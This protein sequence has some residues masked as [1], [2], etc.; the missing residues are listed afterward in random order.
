MSGASATLSGLFAGRYLIERELGQGGTAVVYLARD[1]Q[2]GHP[3]AIKVLRLEFAESVGAERFLREIRVSQQ[4]HHP[5]IASV[6]DSGQHEGRLFFVL[7]LMEGGT[8]RQRLEHERQLAVADAITITKTV[9]TALTHA[10][11]RGLVHRDV[12]PE[13]ILFTSGQACLA[14]FGIARALE[15]ALGEST[16]SSN[17]VRGTPQYM[18]PEQASGSRNYDG[19]TDIYAL[20]CCAYEMLAGMPPFVGPTPENLLAQKL[21]QSPRPV[22]TYRPSLPRAVEEVL[23]KGLA[24]APADR[25]ANA[26]AFATALESA[27]RD[28]SKP[29]PPRRWWWILG[30]VAAAGVVA[31]TLIM[32]SGRAERPESGPPAGDPRR[33][34]VLYLDDLTPATLPPHVADG[35]T[36]DL[37]DQLGGVRALHVT[38]PNGV[39]RYRGSNVA[40]DSVARTL[41]VGTIVAGSVARSGNQM[42]ANVRLID[43]ATGRQ[44]YSTTI[45]R[46]WTE[47]F[48][49]QDSLS[50]RIAFVLRARLGEQIALLEHRS[51]TSSVPAWDALQRGEEARRAAAD[52]ELR[53]APEA[54]ALTLRADSLYARAQELDP[55]WSYPA[56]RR[57]RVAH[58]LAFE[59]DPPSTASSA[60]STFESA[61]QRRA[62]WIRREIEFANM[63]AA[64]EPRS[65]E[66]LILRAD[67][68]YDLVN[69]GMAPLDSVAPAIERDLRGAIELRRDAAS[70]HSSLA[71]LYRTEGRFAEAATAA[72]AAI[73]ADAFFEVQRN[74]SMAFF[75]SLHAERFDDAR[76]WCRVGRDH[77]PNDPRFTECEL[78]LL[79]W[80]GRFPINVTQ[81]WKQIRGIE[82]RD[83]V[84]L[85]GATW[86]YRR[87]MVAALLARLG[88]MDSARA[89]LHVVETRPSTDQRTRSSAV[90][91]AYVDVLLGDRA[92]ALDRLEALLRIAPQLRPYVAK[93]PWFRTLRDD[94]RFRA[95]VR[96]TP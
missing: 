43:A 61:A 89:V 34:A 6:L 78:T 49:L 59:S 95:L 31:A 50:D 35:I 20:A 27:S 63:A 72:Q 38:S 51:T 82:A 80:T 7:P 26:T 14:D 79:G 42:R 4:L 56:V 23:A 22:R 54:I 47:L 10:H 46:P 39:R 32:P 84:G 64:R 16:T 94:Q 9:A 40:L 69:V 96:P 71:R 21:T 12:K 77:Y 41:G 1:Q 24:S 36:E 2:R 25:Y 86:E 65:P 48:A 93:H 53:N 76:H 19:R 13:N 57:G 17:V 70:A 90:S 67:A 29:H 52:A 28:E 37:I 45:D 30:T 62:A 73:N 87:L 66:A 18:S 75:T 85:L 83:T 92:R 58:A 44:L 3:V 8:L 5:H 33:I 60:D 81:A 88:L 68:L 55:G 15:H 74:V 11:E 91:E